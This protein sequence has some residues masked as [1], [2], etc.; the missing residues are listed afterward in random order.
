MAKRKAGKAKGAAQDERIAIT[1]LKGS[2]EYH[3]WITAIS[4]ETLIPITSI[5]R[6]AVKTWAEKRGFSPPPER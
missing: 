1:V 6:D 3:A 4:K 5:I 2:P